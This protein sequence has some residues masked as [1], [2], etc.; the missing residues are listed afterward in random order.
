MDLPELTV[1]VDLDEIDSSLNWLQPNQPNSQ[2]EQELEELF[3][4][5]DNSN[6]EVESQLRKIALEVPQLDYSSFRCLVESTRFETPTKQ[7]IEN[8]KSD[9]RIES[10][11]QL[12]LLRQVIKNSQLYNNFTTF[13]GCMCLSEDKIKN[14]FV[15]LLDNIVVEKQK[16]IIVKLDNLIDKVTLNRHQ[17]L[18]KNSNTQ[19]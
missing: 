10:T 9:L 17:T 11:Q 2:I 13:L 4:Y 14:D 12:K 16:I 15:E 19:V 8:I 6:T 7:E 1:D 3:N 5:F 18:N